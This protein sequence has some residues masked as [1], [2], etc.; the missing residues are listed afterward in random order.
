MARL[1]GDEGD[2]GEDGD[3]HDVDEVPVE[4]GDL[5]LGVVARVELAPHA[6]HHEEDR[7]DP[8]AGDVGP[9]EAVEHEE[10]RPEEAGGE[11]E[12]VVQNEAGELLDLVQ[13]EV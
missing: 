8:P 9:V 6:K 11:R 5:D 10:A 12:I 2:G 4:T 3:P 7:R 13:Y 1:L